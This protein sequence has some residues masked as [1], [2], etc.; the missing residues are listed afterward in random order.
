MELGSGQFGA[1][2]RK[3]VHDWISLVYEFLEANKGLHRAI[4]SIDVE[5]SFDNIDVHMLSDIMS[6]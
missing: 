3:C 6:A 4:L 5:G 1:Q 2:K